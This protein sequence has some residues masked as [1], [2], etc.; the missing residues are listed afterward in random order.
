M[1]E[2]EASTSSNSST[3]RTHS[4]KNTSE[5][6]SETSRT[7]SSSSI[8]ETSNPNLDNQKSSE[9]MAKNTKCT[10]QDDIFDNFIITNKGDFFSDKFF[11]E[12]HEQ[13]QKAVREAM[14]E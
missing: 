11:S 1:F 14:M 10:L 12:C 7:E 5:I 13:F 6:K 2:T 9:S 4:Q 3:R 8:S